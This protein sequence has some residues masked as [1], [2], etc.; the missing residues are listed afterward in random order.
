MSVSNDGSPSMLCIKSGFI[1]LNK[2]K[3]T[4][5]ISI[6]CLINRQVLVLRVISEYLS[7]ILK[8]VIKTLH[9]IKSSSLFG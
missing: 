5:V 3:S 2:D 1:K 4:E 8:K 7:T 9:F 6:H